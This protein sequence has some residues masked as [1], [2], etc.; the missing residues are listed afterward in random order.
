MF[1]G[2]THDAYLCPV[3]KR[4][5][6]SW[7]YKLSHFNNLT[8]RVFS[9]NFRFSIKKT[10]SPT[11]TVPRREKRTEIRR[12]SYFFETRKRG[13][14]VFRDATFLSLS[15]PT[16]YILYS[17]VD[18]VVMDQLASW[19]SNL[20]SPSDQNCQ[21]SSNSSL[22]ARIDAEDVVPCLTFS[23]S[24]MSQGILTNVRNN[25]LM[26]EPLLQPITQ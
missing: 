9:M 24:V 14:G 15:K 16:R 7:T 23:N 5:L 25:T 8:Q 22:L 11:E 26:I 6:A 18:L 10:P 3:T 20:T 4:S 17:Q 1:K 21:S 2:Q 13:S 19:L 12:K